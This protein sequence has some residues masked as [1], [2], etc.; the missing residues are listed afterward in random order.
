MGYISN[1]GDVKDTFYHNY[2]KVV[3]FC[4]RFQNKKKDLMYII[5]SKCPTKE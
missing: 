2:R 5:M 1:H 4:H 3:L